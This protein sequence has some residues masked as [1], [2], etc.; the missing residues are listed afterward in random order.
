[1]VGGAVVASPLGARAQKR[2]GAWP[3]IILVVQQVGPGLQAPQGLRRGLQELGYEDGRDFSIEMYSGK[4]PELATELARRQ[5]DVIF[6]NGAQGV[7]AAHR[8]TR[9]VPI[10][11][12]DLE[13]EP[14]A[15]GL[16]ESYARP[17]G[18][19]TGFFLDQPLGSK[20]LQLI[21]EALPGGSR[22]ALLWDPTVPATQKRSIEEAAQK[23]GLELVAFEMKPELQRSF[24]EIAKVDP[25]AL[26]ILPS[27]LVMQH[28]AEIADLAA[29]AHLP[30]ITMFR[31]YAEG[32]GLMAYGPDPGALGQRAAS[33][34][35]RILKG[36][37]PGEL[38]VEQPSKFDLVIN[39]KTAKSLGL[40]IPASLLA[41]A[42]EVIE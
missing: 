37:K 6:A 18:N 21:S 17:G 36:A 32:G 3:A 14:I 34:V 5:I 41:Q 29:K 28:R 2:T 8:G 22:I 19:L 7:F 27:V 39:L 42:N 31:V 23:M 15:A 38:P 12:L 20:W 9:T 26:L 24:A 13:T 11:A 4:L 10:I 33:Y 30:S 16:I 1:M 25:K 35:D 40:T